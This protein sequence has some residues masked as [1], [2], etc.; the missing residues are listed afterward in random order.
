MSEAPSRGRSRREI[1]YLSRDTVT[2][3]V[4]VAMK[5][6][7]RALYC[8]LYP[9]GLILTRISLLAPGSPGFYHR[10]GILDSPTPAA[11]KNR[12]RRILHTGPRLRPHA[13]TGTPHS[14]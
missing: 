11:V 5:S 12:S 4:S 7:L 14:S 6:T 10:L 8:F 13:V 9:A 1:K 3:V 2:V